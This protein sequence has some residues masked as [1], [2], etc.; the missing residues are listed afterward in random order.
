[1][2]VPADIVAPVAAFQGTAAAAR[3]CVCGRFEHNAPSNGSS[4]YGHFRER[5][6]NKKREPPRP[7]LKEREK[8]KEERK[9][10]STAKHPTREGPAV[11]TRYTRSTTPLS[12][13]HAGSNVFLQ[14][15]AAKLRAPSLDLRTY[16]ALSLLEQPSATS[17][18]S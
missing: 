7:P 1:M 9:S 10:R 11:C 5:E 3:A 13:R 8:K 12:P 17:P 14:A 6:K 4:S 2:A 16:L 18:S 15:A